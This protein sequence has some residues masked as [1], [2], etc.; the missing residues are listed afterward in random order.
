MNVYMCQLYVKEFCVHDRVNLWNDCFQIALIMQR[1]MGGKILTEVYTK[2]FRNLSNLI[3]I[4]TKHFKCFYTYDNI[5][6][7]HIPKV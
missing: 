3:K 2:F 6:E 5:R 7:K 4:F 1:L